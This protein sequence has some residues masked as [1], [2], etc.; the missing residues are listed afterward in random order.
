MKQRLFPR[1][2]TVYRRLR[3]CVWAANDRL[4]LYR[5]QVIPVSHNVKIR[6]DAM[7]LFFEEDGAFKVGT[8]MS[9]TDSAC[10]VELPTGKRIKVKR[11]HIFVTYNHCSRIFRR[12]RYTDPAGSNDSSSAFQSCLFLPKRP[13]QISQGACGDTEAGLSRDWKK[14]KTRRAER[15]LCSDAHRGAQGAGRN[16]Q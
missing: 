14:E 5:E 4:K 2:V 10:Q 9:G 7:N 13:R 1:R 6:K 8:E 16:C 3:I 11:S 12:Q 15:L